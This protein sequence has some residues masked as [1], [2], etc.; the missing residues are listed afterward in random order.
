LTIIYPPLSPPPPHPPTH[1]HRARAHICPNSQGVAEAQYELGLAYHT[2]RG[3]DQNLSQGRRWMAAAAAQVPPPPLQPPFTSPIPQ[4][5]MRT[6][7][8]KWSLRTLPCACDGAQGHDEAI[9][10]MRRWNTAP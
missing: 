4:C 7:V 3:Y 9:T 5:I 10:K 6:V 2:G 8:G 1:P